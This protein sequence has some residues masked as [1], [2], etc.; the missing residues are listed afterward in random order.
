MKNNDKSEVYTFKRLAKEAKKRLKSGYWEDFE[1]RLNTKKAEAVSEGNNPSRVVEYYVKR[2][3]KTVNSGRGTE[4]E[5]Y[6][7]VKKLLLEH[8]EVSNAIGRLIDY[9]IY[10]KMSYEQKQRYTLEISNKYL[11]ALERFR[12][13]KEFGCV[14]NES[15]R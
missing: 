12:K 8:G 6:L 10:D 4:D 15:K 7:K 2:E 5:F 9:S 3:I 13:E 11:E 1:N 14:E